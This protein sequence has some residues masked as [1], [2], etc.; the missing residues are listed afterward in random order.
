MDQGNLDRIA[1][2]IV[3]LRAKVLLTDNH[4]KL[5]EA[6]G[7]LIAT[8]RAELEAGAAQEAYGVAVVGNPGSGK[9]TALAHLFRTHPTLQLLQ[10]DVV[11]ADVASFLVPS[12]STLKMVGLSCLTGLGYPLRRDRTAGIIWE[13][14]QHHLKQRQTLLLHL[15]EA[16]DLMRT[17]SAREMTAVVNTLKSL[18]QG[19]DW[20]V[21][22]VLS[23]LPDLKEL[24]NNDTQLGRRFEPIE[25]AP[26]S[27]EADGGN[28]AKIVER[29]G[30]DANL[31]VDEGILGRDAV[32]RIIYSGSSEL[33]I[34]IQLIIEA[35]REAMLCG[36]SH[37]SREHFIRAF[38]RR[39]G[40]VDD[41]N[42]F[43]REDFTEIDPRL[44]LTTNE[45]LV[46]ADTVWSG[47]K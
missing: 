23:G 11:Q 21:G 26:I 1:K 34:T 39:S 41:L 44:L 25:F 29:Y 16:Q 20:P 2:V 3:K 17:R 38:S 46:T 18:M 47:L 36:S 7:L 37:L 6:I 14:V 42:P 5:E 10:P 24:L 27:F 43:V 32:Q 45:D 28:V 15:D 22:L 31:S 8:R 40:C 30:L 19:K 4:R 35:I 9:S 33:G 13:L 12:P